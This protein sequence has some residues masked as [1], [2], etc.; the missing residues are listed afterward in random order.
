[1]Y[2]CNVSNCGSG[3]CIHKSLDERCPLCDSKMVEVTTTGFKFCSNHESICS[4]EKSTNKG[5][6]NEIL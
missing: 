6:S 4:Y 3:K 2:K 1:M 5:I